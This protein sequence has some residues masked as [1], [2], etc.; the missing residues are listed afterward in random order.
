MLI[1]LMNLKQL[2]QQQI[3]QLHLILSLEDYLYS[4]FFPNIGREHDQLSDI[5]QSRSKLPQGCDEGMCL[6]APSN[7]NSGR[8]AT[9]LVSAGLQWSLPSSHLLRSPS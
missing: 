5:L 8:D 9:L 7:S 2:M 4:I 6:N 1:P 3:L